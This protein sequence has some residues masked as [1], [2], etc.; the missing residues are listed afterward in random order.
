MVSRKVEAKVLS[1]FSPP[2]LGLGGRCMNSASFR[3]PRGHAARQSTNLVLEQP[4][5]QKGEA[6]RRNRARIG[7]RRP[8]RPGPRRDRRRTFDKQRGLHNPP[9]GPRA[10]R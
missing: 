2:T 4:I 10:G 6:E 7:H 1:S 3:N 9:T 8:R 5:A